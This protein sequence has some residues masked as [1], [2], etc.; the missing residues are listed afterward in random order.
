[1]GDNSRFTVLKLNSFET[2]KIKKIWEDSF[3]PIGIDRQKIP[4][5]DMLWHIFSYKARS[6][7]V[8]NRQEIPLKIF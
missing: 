2:T 8:V 3:V 7:K 6:V 1:M 5:E 4:Y